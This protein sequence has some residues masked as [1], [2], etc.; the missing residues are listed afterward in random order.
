MLD[1]DDIEDLVREV[2]HRE[3]RVFTDGYI[4]ASTN[5]GEIQLSIPDFPSAIANRVED[6]LVE[7][8]TYHPLQV[9]VFQS[10]SSWYYWVYFGTVFNRI[11]TL[12]GGSVITT[13]NA[14]NKSFSADRDVYLEL[15]KDTTLSG[16]PNYVDPYS[17]DVSAVDI[18]D[19]LTTF[20]PAANFTQTTPTSPGDDSVQYIHLARLNWNGGAPTVAQSLQS[21][22]TGA[23]DGGP[24]NPYLYWPA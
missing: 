9:S 2:L 24:G 7:E 16:T 21:S 8:E 17:G 19:Q 3:L 13:T 4:R 20:D 5:G 15:S 10:G 18:V 6:S 12:N 11:P 23:R 22:I 1:R 14:V